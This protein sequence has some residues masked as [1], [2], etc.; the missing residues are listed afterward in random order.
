MTN[1]D[2][3]TLAI[4]HDRASRLP[5]S[6][7]RSSVSSGAGSNAQESIVR[8]SYDQVSYVSGLRG[9]QH[10]HNLRHVG[11]GRLINGRSRGVG[12]P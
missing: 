5:F 4:A 11:D 9:Q 1:S 2:A 10:E 3:G 8:M 12:P 6:T 7:R